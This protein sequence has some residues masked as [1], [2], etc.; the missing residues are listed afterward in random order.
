MAS[1]RRRR[2]A[3]ATVPAALALVCL[4]FGSV[5]ARAGSAWWSPVALSGVAITKVFAT[6]D[7]IMVRTGAGTTL[8]STDAAR[9]FT[10]V[11]GNG[12]FPPAGTVIAGNTGWS[13]DSSHRVTHNDDL[14]GGGAVRTDPA[15]P[16]LGAGAD[17]LA[18]PAALPGVVVAVS[19]NGTVW[20]RGQDG[21][22]KQALLLLPQ[23][24]VQGVPRV[25]S[26]TA[27]TQPLSDAIYLGTDG[28]A[29]LISTDGGD[30]WIRA[31][32]GLPSSVYAL[33]ADSARHAVYAGTSN[34]L[35]VHVLQELPSPPAYQDA[36]L[37]WR[38]IGIGAAT[39]VAAAL[40]LLGLLRVMPRRIPGCDPVS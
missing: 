8:S 1:D 14:A 23:S 27:F 4:M 39:L 24:L 22:W 16:D 20:R 26:V 10:T 21:D 19:T 29:V 11:Q 2:T 37:V 38:W 7:T 34:G 30:D 13:I 5:P 25:T 35:W 15:S 32:P 17:L 3:T 9:T 33:S 31:G 12:T 18:A 28:Y 40:T 36:A 6:G